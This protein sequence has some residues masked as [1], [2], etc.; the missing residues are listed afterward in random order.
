MARIRSCGD[1]GVSMTRLNSGAPTVKRRIM[2][3]RATVSE[4]L[5]QST[6]HL[7]A[8]GNTPTMPAS[9]APIAA[10]ESLSPQLA[11]RISGIETRP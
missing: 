10:A 7:C 8:P 4:A 5:T 2:S 6:L 1:L 9:S 3:A 11:A